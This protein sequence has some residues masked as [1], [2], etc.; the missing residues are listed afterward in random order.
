MEFYKIKELK[1]TERDVLALYKYY[2]EKGKNKC[3]SMTNDQIADELN[4]STR[5]LREIKKHLKDLGYIRTDGGIKVTY[6]G[7]KGGATVPGGEELQLLKGGT[8]APKRRSYSSTKEELQLPHKKEKKEKKEEKKGMTNLDLLL[9]R[10]PKEYLTPERI[11]YI[12]NNFMDRL[13]DINFNES[14]ILDTWVTGIKVELNK[15]FPM[16]YIEKKKEVKSNTID[17]L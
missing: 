14:G 15:R 3:C 8:T 1:G 9:G 6:L 13:N 17:L 7:V 2:T 5:Y 10:L 12:K 4:I 16:E 11:E